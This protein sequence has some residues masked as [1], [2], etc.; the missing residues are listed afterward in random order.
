MP[1]SPQARDARAAQ[2]LDQDR[3]EL[4]VAVMRSQEP[5]VRV[6]VRRERGIAGL[7][8]RGLD[9]RAARR[10]EAER[11]SSSGM[12]AAR[13]AA[14]QAPPRLG[15]RLQAMIDVDGAQRFT[16]SPPPVAAI[17][18]SRTLESRPPESATQSPALTPA[19]IDG[20]ERGC[21]RIRPRTAP[22]APP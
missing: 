4:V 10:R 17:A 8:R 13:Q 15:T 7:A 19:G 20:V 22:Q 12:P 9:A 18:C 11:R 6:E 16:R 14:A 1:A 2:E 5:L 21:E 3:L